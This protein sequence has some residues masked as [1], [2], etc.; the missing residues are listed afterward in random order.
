MGKVLGVF[1]ISN[2]IVVEEVV[3]YKVKQKKKGMGD[4]Q[5][6]QEAVEENRSCKEIITTEKCAGNERRKKKYRQSKPLMKSLIQ[7]SKERVERQFR[8]ALRLGHAGQ[9]PVGPTRIEAAC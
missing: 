2:R 5:I 8:V 6:R 9:L 7:G 3:G 4:G 1:K